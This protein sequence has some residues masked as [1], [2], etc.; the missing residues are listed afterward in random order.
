M[1]KVDIEDDI[2]MKCVE[3]CQYYHSE[4]SRWSDKFFEELGRKFFVTPTSFLELLKTFDQLLKE[5]NA[6]V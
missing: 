3:I 2:K 5:N 6:R 4:T 1:S